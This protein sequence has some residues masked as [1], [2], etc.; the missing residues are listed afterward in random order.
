LSAEEG[1][2]VVRV[3]PRETALV[4]G[5]LPEGLHEPDGVDGALAVDRRPS[6]VVG[7]GTA[8]VPQQRV[9]PRGRVTEGVSQR[10]P[11]RVALF[12]SFPPSCRSSPYLFG[13]V[14]TPISSNH[15]FR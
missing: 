15:D 7:L 13:N 4:A 3:V 11:V 9:R 2:V 14:V 6:V 5:L 1:A 10:L 8:K 12:L